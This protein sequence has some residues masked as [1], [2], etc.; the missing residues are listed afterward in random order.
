MRAKDIRP[1]DVVWS[2]DWRSDRRPKKFVVHSK[3]RDRVNTT[4]GLRMR[5]KHLHPTKVACLEN[6]YRE[7][8]DLLEEIQH[9]VDKA[10]GLR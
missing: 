10:K 7:V 5:A 3:E 4:H 9:M 1:G 6:A 8:Y 2:F